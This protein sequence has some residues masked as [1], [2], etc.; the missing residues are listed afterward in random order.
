MGRRFEDIL[1]KCLERVLRGE[2][3]QDCLSDYPEHRAQLEPLLRL[4]VATRRTSSALEPRP[5]FKDR[6]R[7]EVRS[8]AT[9]LAGKAVHRGVPLIS[10]VPRWAVVVT[11]LVLVLLVAGVGTAAASSSSMPDDTL[12]PVKLATEQVQLSLSRGNISRARVHMRLVDRR[13]REIVYLAEKG[14]ARRLNRTL[15]RLTAHMEAIKRLIEEQNADRPE[16]QER[17][18]ALKMLLEERAMENEALITAATNNTDDSGIMGRVLEGY[19]QAY[20]NALRAG[21]RGSRW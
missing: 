15:V 5:E 11:S 12:Y 17:V 18:A 1:D 19:R 21:W 10:W 7:Y 13:V 3:I 16:D 14:D 20:Q 8:R 4:A 9:L 2:S 6:T